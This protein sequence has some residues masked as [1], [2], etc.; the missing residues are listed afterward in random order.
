MKQNR[1]ALALAA[2][3]LAVFI[4]LLISLLV[5]IV[6]GNHPGD[7][8]TIVHTKGF[9]LRTLIL[10]LNRAAPYYLSGVAVAIGFK[11]N[12]FNI[13]V[14][15]Q[16]RL[17]A[18]VAA[19]AGAAVNIPGPLHVVFILVV[20][21][22][23]G[24]LW[25]S[26]AAILR[27][28]RGVSEVIA[29]IMLNAI[30][31]GLTAFMLTR[32]FKGGKTGTTDYTVGTKPFKASGALPTLDRLVTGVGLKLP[33]G[34]HFQAYILIAALIGIGY[35]LLVW[36]TRL[37]YDL[38]AS[39]LNPEAARASGVSAKRM[40]IIAM[41][42]SGAIAGLVGLSTMLSETPHRYT[43]D[44]V[45]AGFGFTGIA[46]ALLGRNN[47]VGIAIGALLWAFMDILRTPLAQAELPPQIVTILQGTVVLSV[48]IAYEL[49]RRIAERREATELARASRD[50]PPP[51]PEPSPAGASA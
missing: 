32:W 18:L 48:V 37:G 46:V 12:L 19:A 41:G 23:V 39:G 8:W 1:I 38:R 16:Y 9:T 50:A 44:I 43:D 36:R 28:T 45:T 13:G 17:A 51:E 31:S 15:G 47:P 11:M 29:T 22:G 35:W 40:V 26:I 7:V 27:V 49:V 3:A 5:L 2:P 6:S 42:L 33:Q 4:A 14:E 25:A 10:T 20:A 21:M 34:T 24:C 30:A